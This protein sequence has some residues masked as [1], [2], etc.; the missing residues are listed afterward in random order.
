MLLGAKPEANIDVSRKREEETLAAV[1]EDVGRISNPSEQAESAGRFGKPSYG[2][3][4]PAARRE[5][6]AAAG[7]ELL[8]AVF[9]FLGELVQEGQPAPTE[10][11]GGIA[12]STPSQSIVQGIRNRLD[13]CV[14]E[15]DGRPRLTLTLPDRSALDHLAQ[16]LSRLLVADKR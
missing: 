13:E 11:D 6:V 2:T 4:G 9:R 12:T 8:G 3:G 1:G 16:A 15:E 14:V 7:G 5:R 10:G